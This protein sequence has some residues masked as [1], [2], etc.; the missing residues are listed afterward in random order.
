MI[1]Q[2]AFTG[3]GRLLKGGLHCHTTR[4]DGQGTPEEVMRLHAQ[5]GYDFLAITDHR[6][7]NFTNF[8]PDTGMV[9]IPG[10][11]ID[12]N[13]P[14]F[15]GVHCYHTVVLGLPKEMGNPY[16]QDQLFASRLVDTQ[17]QF[18]EMLDMHHAA[19]QMTMYCHP[20]W[21]NTPAREFD[22]LKGNFA[23]EIWNSGC[24]IDNGL[25]T[26]AAYWDELL[27][28]GQKL[29]G[30]ATDDGHPMYH[31]CKGWVRVNAEKNVPAILEALKNGAFYAST[32]PE[33]YD[34]YVKDGV[35][36]VDCSPCAT[37]DFRNGQF[38]CP[39]LHSEEG[40]LTHHEFTVNP[41]WDWRYIRAVVTD[42]KGR[43][44]WT[45]PIFAK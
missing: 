29:Y 45:N 6:K 22:R 19:G 2:A 39:R 16:E 38:P 11:E 33:I 27:M 9:V 17:E 41:K 28:Q 37:I 1:R 15:T 23:M 40:G 34:F 32:G 26:D 13:I 3:T 4:S 18:Q 43:K 8:A 24:V 12:A 5:N 44:A 10:M 42:A 21:S 30:C 36:A 20:E 7:Y 31:H 25:D 14:D 35:V